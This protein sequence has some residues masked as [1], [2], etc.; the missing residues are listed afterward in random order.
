MF[1]AEVP[2]DQPTRIQLVLKLA[3]ADSF[4]PDAAIKVVAPLE[5]TH[6]GPTEMTVRDPD[7]RMW[8][9]QAPAKD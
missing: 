2:D 5:A 8:I 7:G 4:E 9:L 1:I 3:D 6:H